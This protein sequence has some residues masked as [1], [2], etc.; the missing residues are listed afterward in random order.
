M[1]LGDYFG[2]EAGVRYLADTGVLGL[3]AGS[4]AVAQESAEESNASGGR[5]VPSI[6]RLLEVSVGSSTRTQQERRVAQLA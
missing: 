1:G 6:R 3:G 4:G 2:A 5:E